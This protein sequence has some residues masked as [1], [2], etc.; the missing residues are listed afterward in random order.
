LTG[1][2]LHQKQ[3]FE[4]EKAEQQEKFRSLM[5]CDFKKEIKALE[6]GVCRLEWKKN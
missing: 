1:K 5:K 2:E 4:K 6:D 3:L